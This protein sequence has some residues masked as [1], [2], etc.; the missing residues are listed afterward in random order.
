MVLTWIS[1][2]ISHIEHI[3]CSCWPSV[4]LFWKKNIY[5]NN[6]PIFN[7]VCFH[8][9]T[10]YVELYNYL[11]IWI[12]TPYKTCTWKYLLFSM[13]TFSFHIVE[14]LL[15]FFYNSFL[16]QC[17]IISLLWLCFHF[18]R[19]HTSSQNIAKAKVKECT[20]C[21]FLGYNSLQSY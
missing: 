2:R 11:Y 13:W 8:F 1:P 21:L 14:N 6:L 17:S 19:I 16:F 9:S 4:C 3:Y 20:A 5:A 18:L 15:F 10:S 12:L 7:Q